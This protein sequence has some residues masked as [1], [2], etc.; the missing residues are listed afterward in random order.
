[1]WLIDNS[2]QDERSSFIN[3]AGPWCRILTEDM[4]VYFEIHFFFPCFSS[5]R[6]SSPAPCVC[7]EMYILETSRQAFHSEKGSLH[8]GKWNSVLRKGSQ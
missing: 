8:E 1:M 5:L 3:K 6:P 4:P 2:V 7:A